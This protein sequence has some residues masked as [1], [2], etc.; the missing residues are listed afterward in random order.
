MGVA[1]KKLRHLK[2][3]LELYMHHFMLRR[4]RDEHKARLEQCVNAAE[5]GLNLNKDA[6]MF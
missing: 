4:C 3:G 1:G 6:V 2:E 5:S